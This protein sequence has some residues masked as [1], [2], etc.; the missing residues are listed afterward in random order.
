MIL[1]WSQVTGWF[2][3]CFLRA[4]YISSPRVDLRPKFVTT[5]PMWVWFQYNLLLSALFLSLRRF[6]EGWGSYWC[7]AVN[8]KLNMEI[9]HTSWISIKFL[10]TEI[11]RSYL[12]NIWDGQNKNPPKKKELLFSPTKSSH[13]LDWGLLKCTYRSCCCC[14]APPSRGPPGSWRCP[15]SGWCQRDTGT[16]SGKR[17]RLHSGSLWREQQMGNGK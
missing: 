12:S 16:C 15:A 14:S 3:P 1:I 10:S 7:E 8:R 2:Y 13:L 5:L 6:L 4:I 17:T 9:K 11:K